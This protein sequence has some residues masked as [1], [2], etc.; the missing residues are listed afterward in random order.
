[1]TL[2]SISGSAMLFIATSGSLSNGW[3]RTRYRLS[4][5]CNPIGCSEQANI[6]GHLDQAD[7]MIRYPQSIAF[8]SRR[9]P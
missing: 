9:L 8:S 4:T 3:S 6:L 2:D 1:M 7:L 5:L